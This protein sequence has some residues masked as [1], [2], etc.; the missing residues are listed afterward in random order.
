MSDGWIDNLYSWQQ[1]AGTCV[2]GA[3]HLRERLPMVLHQR[4]P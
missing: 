3:N 4:A 1:A 2:D